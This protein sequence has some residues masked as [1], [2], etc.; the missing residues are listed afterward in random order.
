MDHISARG[1]HPWFS[2]IEIEYVCDG[3]QFIYDYRDFQ[4]YPARVGV[5]IKLLRKDQLPSMALKDSAPFVQA[6][7]WFGLLIEALGL[8]SMV[9]TD[10]VSKTFLKTKGTQK[11]LCTS[12]LDKMIQETRTS[13]ITHHHDMERLYS[14]IQDT[15]DFSQ[16]VLSS[17]WAESQIE[18][19][20]IHHQVFKSILASQIL[21]R[22]LLSA[23]YNSYPAQTQFPET[24]LR[25][26]DILLQQADWCPREIRRLNPDVCLRYYISLYIRYPVGGDPTHFGSGGCACAPIDHEAVTPQHTYSAC[27]C[28]T[29]ATP[30]A[31]ID[32][33]VSDGKV[34][35]VRFCPNSDT[36]NTLEVK[37]IDITGEGKMP[38]VAV[39]HVR[40][41]G[42]GNGTQNSLP[43]CQIKLIQSL[44][45]QLPKSNPDSI[46]FWIDTLCVPRERH[47]RK[48]ALRLDWK[49]F[50]RAQHTL[51]L[52]PPLYQ[53]KFYTSE[54]ALIRIR[55]ST[56]KMRLWTLKEGF[57]ARNLIFRFNDR[58]VSL[59]ELLDDFDEYSAT[60]GKGL[61]VLLKVEL[62]F[63]QDI[64]EKGPE[65]IKRF[66]EDINFWLA[67]ERNIPEAAVNRCKMIL[68][69][70]L[71]LA[72]LSARK[73]QYLV[74]N[75]E[76]QQIPIVWK[77][78]Q[79]YE[80]TA[81]QEASLCTDDSNSRLLRI[82]TFCK[83]YLFYSEEITNPGIK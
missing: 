7:L 72:Y 8:H 55:Y 24:T 28:E 59:R 31:L 64:D 16:K 43:S 77:A 76:L 12:Q 41:A 5:D 42:L 33:F 30:E 80:D 25:I 47:L 35:L 60:V 78:L 40:M 63:Q 66:E 69:R 10:F 17:T 58:L 73:F 1:D 23:F 15:L 18:E 11:Y 9:E 32:N 14:C 61:A 81:N 44:A 21:C 36:S 65:L 71:R 26:V 38:F 3:T 79:I 27:D 29:I 54:D 53:H 45:D 75:D 56:W 67:K 4:G 68:Y 74:E 49:L 20:V 52:D 48:S 50:A 39:S 57:L 83:I 37:G 2:P 6:W 51:I 22:T 46:F 19:V 70:A 13:G 62:P 82:V 34:V